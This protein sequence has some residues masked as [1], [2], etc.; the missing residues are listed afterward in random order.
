MRKKQCNFQ[1]NILHKTHKNDIATIPIPATIPQ[2][3]FNVVE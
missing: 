3:G 2:T 1:M